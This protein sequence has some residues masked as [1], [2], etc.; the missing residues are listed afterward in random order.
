MAGRILK[1]L[2]LVG[3]LDEMFDIYKGNC[4]LFMGIAALIQLPVSLAAYAIGGE[5]TYFLSAFA[6]FPI[7]FITLAAA[8]WAVSQIYLGSRVTILGAYKNVLRRAWPFVGTM[9]VTS[10]LIWFGFMLLIIPGIYFAVWYAFVSEVFIIE[11]LAWGNARKRSKALAS[12]EYNRIVLLAIL[13]WILAFVVKMGLTSLVGILV[14]GDEAVMSG[15][16][17]GMLYGLSSAL[18]QALTLPFSVIA[19]V[20]LYYDIRVRREGFDIQ[21][22]AQNL[23]ETAGQAAAEETPAT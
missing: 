7:T 4:L 2:S 23:A 20:L 8:T 5:Y 13:A 10:L 19:F 1:P 18:S 22:L 3:L 12:G 17:N 11:G 6:M 14:G 9:L 21:M 15:G 16:L